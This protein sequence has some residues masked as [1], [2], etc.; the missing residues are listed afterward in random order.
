MAFDSTIGFMKARHQFMEST[1]PNLPLP[2]STGHIGGGHV[3]SQS[4]PDDL[5]ET[6][7]R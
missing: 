3:G 2:N 4:H 5:G 7:I 1:T 6:V